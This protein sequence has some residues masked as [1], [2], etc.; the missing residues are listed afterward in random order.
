MTV[1]FEFNNKTGVISFNGIP[2]TSETA[3]VT[4]TDATVTALF[5]KAIDASTARVFTVKVAARDSGDTLR[6]GYRRTTLVHRLGAGG[7]VL[8]IVQDDFTDESDIALDCSFDVTGNDL[9]VIVTGK[10]ATNIIWNGS[11]TSTK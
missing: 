10:A 4:T 9:R 1:G 7:A 11:L 3:T 2:I 5:T 8:G 6:S